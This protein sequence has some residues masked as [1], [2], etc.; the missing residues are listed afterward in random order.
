LQVQSAKR[1]GCWPGIW[2]WFGPEHGDLIRVEVT[3]GSWLLDGEEVNFMPMEPGLM[4][5]TLSSI[6]WTES[7]ISFKLRIVRENYQPLLT[8]K[9][10]EGELF[11][12]QQVSVPVTIPEG[13]SKATF[14]LV[15]NRDWSKFPTSDID[16]YIIDPDGNIASYD[17]ASVNAPERAVIY[18][19]MPGEWSVFIDGY[20]LYKPDHYTLYLNTE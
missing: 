5:V 18:N 1:G 20:E 6:F 17:G 9:I 13:V 15:F 11:G 16:M 4:K 3:D 14:D 19:P 8:G 10:A 2:W 12:F 7:P